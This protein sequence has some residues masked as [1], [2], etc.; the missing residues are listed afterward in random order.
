MGEEH[1]VKMRGRPNHDQGEEQSLMDDTELELEAVAASEKP[2]SAR[3]QSMLMDWGKKLTGMARTFPICLAL[4]PLLTLLFVWT[5]YPCRLT[6][7]EYQGLTKMA[8]DFA[9]ALDR[10]NASWVMCEGTLIGAVRDG[11]I[12]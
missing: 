3:V 10:H 7:S 12:M 9:G 11:C 6:T 8:T 5:E 4:V 2:K 1:K